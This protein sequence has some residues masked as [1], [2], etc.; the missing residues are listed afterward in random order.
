MQDADSQIQIATKVTTVSGSG[1]GA[2][3]DKK[4]ENEDFISGQSVARNKG[5]MY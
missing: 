3:R 1:E 4:S 5:Q 2:S